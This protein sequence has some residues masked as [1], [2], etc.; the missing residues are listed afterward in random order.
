MGR[1]RA[2]LNGGIG[3]VAAVVGLWGRIASLLL[4]LLSDARVRLTRTP[5]VTRRRVCAGVVWWPVLRGRWWWWISVLRRVLGVLRVLRVVVAAVAGREALV[6]VT[7]PVVRGRMRIRIWMML[8]LLLL[9]LLLRLRLY[10]S[11]LGMRRAVGMRAV[12]RLCRRVGRVRARERRGLVRLG[13]GREGSVRNGRRLERATLRGR[14]RAVLPHVRVVVVRARG[15]RF[16]AS[17]DFGRV[18]PDDVPAGTDSNQSTAVFKNMT[19]YALPLNVRT[20]PAAR[21]CERQL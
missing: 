16:L 12:H 21:R 13:G 7:V 8:G 20:F 10:G 6:R 18:G 4:L 15:G 1:A 14:D 9:L 17:S 11:R 3:R 19:W 5:A 2:G